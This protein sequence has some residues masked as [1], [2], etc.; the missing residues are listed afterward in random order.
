MTIGLIG[1]KCGITQETQ[2][3]LVP[4]CLT[5]YNDNYQPNY[6]W[7]KISGNINSR[8]SGNDPLLCVTVNEFFE[9]S[10]LLVNHS[11]TI[12]AKEYKLDF[13]AKP[14]DRYTRPML[15][16]GIYITLF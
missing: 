15:T 16:E 6:F 11:V 13:S 4:P 8:Y 1:K 2:S 12:L 9:A 7:Y 10:V 14:I 3:R 5:D